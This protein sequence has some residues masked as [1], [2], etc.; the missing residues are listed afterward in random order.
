MAYYT[1]PDLLLRYPGDLQK[2]AAAG[3]S[4]DNPNPA[5]SATEEAP[6]KFD[7]PFIRL[8]IHRRRGQLDAQTVPLYPR[9]LIPGCPGLHPYS[10]PRPAGKGCNPTQSDHLKKLNSTVKSGN[11]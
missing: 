11:I 7:Q 10:Q 6:Q 5:F 9:H 8:S 3:D 2:L 4:P 1:A